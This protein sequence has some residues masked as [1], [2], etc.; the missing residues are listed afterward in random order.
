MPGGFVG[1]D[2]K[3]RLPDDWPQ[4]CAATFATYGD[5]CHVCHQAGADEVDHVQAG[6]DHSL[7]NLRP[8]HG[9]RTPQR[10]HPIKSSREGNAAR[11]RHK[12]ARPV[13]THPGMI[14]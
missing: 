9:Y 13:E 7:A 6:D 5:I 8:I 2:R 4:R 12:R 11:H 3:Q 1:S 14:T 10:C